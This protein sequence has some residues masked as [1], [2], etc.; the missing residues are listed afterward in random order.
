[1]MDPKD[2][3]WLDKAFGECL[4]K[5]EATGKEGRLLE[6]FSMLVRSI[7]KNAQKDIDEIDRLLHE[8]PE[9]ED[10]PE[11]LESLKRRLFYLE[12]YCMEKID[13]KLDK[14]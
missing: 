8:G 7:A 13:R 3:L 14:S 2:N 5:N 6:G 9:S 1:M 4:G 12:R 11:R 10:L